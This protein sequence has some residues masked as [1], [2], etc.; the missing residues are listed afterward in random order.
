MGI[1]IILDRVVIGR[2][3]NDDK[4]GIAVSRGT[5]ERRRKIELFLREIFFD[6]FVLNRRLAA[7]D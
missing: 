3:S 4:I 7:I 6:V 2:S 5:V 1:E